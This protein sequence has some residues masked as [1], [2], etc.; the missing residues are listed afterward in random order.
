MKQLPKPEKR[1]GLL[2]RLNLFG[3]GRG[4][5]AME[6]VSRRDFDNEI[7][8]ALV[9]WRETVAGE[10]ITDAE[11]LKQSVVFACRRFITGNLGQLPHRVF[12]RTGEDSAV[13]SIA[14]PAHKVLARR[15][16]PEMGPLQFKEVLTG[17]G[18]MSGNGYAEIVRNRRDE[19]ME[20]W[21]IHPSRMTPT[22]VAGNLRYFYTNDAGKTISMDPMDVFHLRGFG[23]GVVGI[24]VVEHAA[25]T[26][27][28]A[29]ATELFGS[30]F[31]GN[32]VHASGALEIPPDIEMS[33]DAMN[34]MKKEF[35]DRRRGARRGLL[36]IFL[37]RG[38]KWI[39]F[40][41]KN[42]DAQ[43]IETLNFQVN[44]IARYF[45]VPPH[46]VND[47]SRA[48][49]SNIIEQSIEVIQDTIMPWVKRFEEEADYKLLL[50]S[51]AHY[52]KFN[53]NALMRGDPKSRAEF[54]RVM[55]MIGAMSPN[56]VRKLEEMNPYE[57]G[58]VY[59]MQGQ[60]VPV[61]MLGK[62]NVTGV[63][64]SPPR[65]P[66]APDEEEDEGDDAG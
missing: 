34:E 7:L 22:R 64:T 18:M 26:I 29:R 58:D 9:G 63:S 42:N 55:W 38:I 43:F 50:N 47:L 49:F 39:Q 23:D 54:Y 19:V 33:T 5:V 12:E 53:L 4:A 37:D 40:G 60:M 13:L 45:G 10:R 17:H 61:P 14:H 52:T 36:P 21:P 48:T 25:E 41:G 65:N 30:A 56:D 27:G 32:G 59:V 2:D 46:K 62:V 51:D 6:R 57:G 3:W 66:A 28:W 11:A 20:L 35:L 8:G 44:Q 15:P 16:N 31:F 24:N 1:P